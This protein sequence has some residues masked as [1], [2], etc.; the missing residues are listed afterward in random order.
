VSHRFVPG[1][2]LSRRLYVDGVAPVLAASF[3]TLRHTAALIGT[4]SDVLGYDTTRST[5]HDWGP[6]L[7]LFLNAEDSRQLGPDLRRLLSER[8][9]KTILGYPTNLIRAEN[10]TTRHMNATDGPV[11]HGVEVTDLVDWFAG[12]LGFDPRGTIETLDWLATPTQVLA[13]VTAGAV[14]HDDIGELT[15]AR[16][17]LAWY[18]RDVWRYVLACQWQRIAE[19][20]SFVG[21]CGEVGDELGSAVVAARLVRDVVRLRLLQH[22]R[23]PPYSKWLGTAF[24]RL[25]DAAYLVPQ[26][27]HAMSAITSSE[28]EEA[29]A[30]TYEHAARAQN[31]LE[32]A[33]FVDPTT[34]PFHTRPFRVL[35]AERFAEAV[36][37]SIADP[38]IRELPLVGTVDQWVD[39]TAAIGR[40]RNLRQAQLDLTDGG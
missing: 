34:R 11:S 2:E 31:Q 27:A 23:Y 12:N 36:R 26:L 1:L 5:D 6:R 15:R 40:L 16:N 7:Q 10:G 13:S 35:H 18:P 39:N 3:P 8:L 9:P 17:Q 28:R 33:P 4:G 21:R 25:P 22:R 30:S 14:F 20:E 24:S 29:L 37:M 38:A 32:L 19:E